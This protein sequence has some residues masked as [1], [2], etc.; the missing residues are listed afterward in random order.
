V[1]NGHTPARDDFSRWGTSLPQI[2][3]DDDEAR[4]TN[5][6]EVSESERAIPHEAT[7]P[8][9]LPTFFIKAYSDP[10]DTWLDPFAGSGTTALA[11]E[12]EGRLGLMVEQLPKYCAV[13]LERLQ[14]HIGTD[15]ELIK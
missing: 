10:L 6:I 1:A 2:N 8:L 7:F 12:N 4:P 9:K 15:P 11:A 13:I 14:S 3:F 5:V